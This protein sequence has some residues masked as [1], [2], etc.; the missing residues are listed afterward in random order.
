MKSIRSYVAY[1]KRRHTRHIYHETANCS[2]MRQ[3]G[4]SVKGNRLGTEGQD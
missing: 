3:T 1:Y 4:S 2:E